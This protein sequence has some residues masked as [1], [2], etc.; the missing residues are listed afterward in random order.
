M[1][2][3]PLT[4]NIS[5]YYRPRFRE[6]FDRL[7]SPY[8]ESTIYPQSLIWIAV[9][10]LVVL[11]GDIPSIPLGEHLQMVGK[12]MPIGAD[13]LW[14]PFKIE[15][16]SVDNGQKTST[17]LE[18]QVSSGAK[19]I[20]LMSSLKFDRLSVD[21]P[22]GDGR[23]AVPAIVRYDREHSLTSSADRSN[24]AV[25]TFTIATADKSWFRSEFD[26]L[27]SS[28]GLSIYPQTLIWLAVQHLIV[29]AGDL[30]QILPSDPYRSI[31]R[32]SPLIRG[33]LWHYFNIGYYPDAAGRLTSH[34][35]EFE[36]ELRVDMQ[37][38]TIELLNAIRH[39]RGIDRIGWQPTSGF[40]DRPWQ[41]DSG[42]PKKV[43]HRYGA[44][45]RSPDRPSS[46]HTAMSIGTSPKIEPSGYTPLPMALFEEQR[47]QLLNNGSARE[48]EVM[49]NLTLDLSM[50]SSISIVELYRELSQTALVCR[51]CRN[52]HGKSYGGRMLVCAIHPSGVG[53]ETS[54]ADFEA[55]AEVASESTS[56]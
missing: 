38:S 31:P 18:L 49:R 15:Y 5:E 11:A 20:Q 34:R 28:R 42:S 21:E 16:E 19:S 36:L 52:Y 7:F 44:P 55:G 35:Y 17:R 4:F 29:R 8:D 23:Q 12:K 2:I 9:W 1:T 41:Q 43:A 53:E 54:C 27:H 50:Q 14:F 37:L 39:D 48:R 24:S 25:P 30:P 10:N 22:I 47:E 40:E 32:E 6:E 46:A 45:D 51:G 3:S 26:R 33:G 13:V 56:I